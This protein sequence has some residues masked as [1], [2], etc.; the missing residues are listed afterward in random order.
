MSSFS[1]NFQRDENK[2]NTQY[3]DSAFYTYAISFLFVLIVINIIL[4]LRRF[5]YKKKFT[6]SKYLNCNCEFCH[7]RLKTIN[8][9]ISNENINLTFYFYIII[10]FALLYLSYLCYFQVKKNSGKIKSFNPYEI[11]EIDEKAD[12]RTIKKA[13]KKLALKFHPDKNPN[14]LQAKAKFIL[15]AKAYE[16]LTNE[17]SK[18]NF[19]K[20]GNPDGPGSMRLSVALPSFIL[21]KKNHLTILVIFLIFILIIV[22]QVF[23]FWY[24]STKEYND[25][26]IKKNDEQVFYFELN[27][28]ILL[29]QMPYVLGLAFEYR[30]LP[31]RQEEANIL[32]ETYNKYYKQNLMC[33]HKL[34]HIHPSN[35]KAI[36][37][38]YS[39][40]MK[41]PLKYEKYYEELNQILLPTGN[42]IEQMYKMAIYFTQIHM[43]N[44]SGNKLIK[45]FGYN[46]IKTIFEFS[47]NLHQQISHFNNPDSG[48]LQLPYFNENKL[49]NLMRILKKYNSKIFNN[50]KNNF[51]EFINLPMEERN[52]ILNENGFGNEEILNINYALDALPKYKINLEIFT[53]GFE[54]IV[55]NDMITYKFTVIRE[56]LPE[57]KILGVNH[58]NNFPLLFDEKITVFILDNNK[59]ILFNKVITIEKRENTFTIQF[60]FVKEGKFKYMCEM[61]SLNYKGLDQSFEFEFEVK[62]N[63]DKRKEQLKQIKSREVKK[64]EATYFQKL[65]NQVVG[66]NAEDDEEEEEEKEDEEDNEKTKTE[67]KKKD[68][69]NNDESEKKE[70]EHEKKD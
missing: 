67:E 44:Q 29:K 34:E 33:K 7:S 54:D 26:G 3:D 10:L 68:E 60:P 45:N 40:I 11:L 14:N 21:D 43:F 2:D 42:F 22:P 28:N 62:K 25:I 4:I 19:E 36:C 27:E 1:E 47:Q 46:C 15:I 31:I 30:D 48:F 5:F 58:S 37:L 65:L 57:D 20:Y 59:I 6:D 12:E 69:K 70:E 16:A 66:I 61:M 32:Y 41:Q 50:N 56:N 63:S 9:K 8:Q 38:L 24:N 39:Y 53:E 35:K 13:Y 51:K 23:L 18:K 64:I 52:K 55:E 17:E 49:K